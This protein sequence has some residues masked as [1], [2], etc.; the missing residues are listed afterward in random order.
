M[1]SGID[2]VGVGRLNELRHCT[3]LRELGAEVVELGDGVMSYSAGVRWVSQASGLG[4]SAYGEEPPLG[5]ATDEE[6]AGHAPV[7]D[8]VVGFYRDRGVTPRVEVCSLTPEPLLGALAAR[9][10]TTLHY[11]NVL[12][13]DLAGPPAAFALPAGV[14]IVRVDKQDGAMV[15]LQAE[16]MTR[17]F[18]TPAEPATEEMVEMAAKAIRDTS[19][20][21]LLAVD[22]GRAVGACGMETREIGG[23]RLAAL[24]GAVVEPEYR[25]RGIQLGMLAHRL[26]VARELGCALAIIESK[27]G[28]ATERNAARAGFG[29]AYVRAVME[30]RDAQ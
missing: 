29:L 13:A 30:Q 21:G 12:A 22:G 19:A 2:W 15:R 10:F 27:P 14:R 24:W 3:L 7:V 26:G 9:A 5:R 4:L 8:R 23:V 25:R 6:S 1:M 18:A 20:I 11:E 28:V 17:M 16:T